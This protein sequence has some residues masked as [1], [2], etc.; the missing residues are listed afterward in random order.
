MSGTAMKRSA[1][2]LVGLSIVVL[3]IG[4]PTLDDRLGWMSSALGAELDERK[5]H[6]D[7]GELLAL[8]NNNHVR[9]DVLDTRPE[10][11]F[12][13][14][15]IMDS[16]RLESEPGTDSWVRSLPATSV[17]VVIAADEKSAEQTWMRLRALGLINVYL[18]E[19]GVDGWLSAYHDGTP[20]RAALGARHPAS[21]PNLATA[22]E[23]KFE[24]KVKVSAGA[25]SAGGGCG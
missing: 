16:R 6:I 17:K 10:A 4:Q 8:L 25:K 7:P 9:L 15:H 14:F 21:R 12:N 18:L 24:K 3:L 2:T 19:G 5:P 13:L 1:A 22:P 11:D 23:R 20:F